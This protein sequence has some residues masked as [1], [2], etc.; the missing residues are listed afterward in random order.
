[1]FYVDTLGLPV[2][3][4]DTKEPVLLGSAMLA[5]CASRD[6]HDL[7]VRPILDESC[8]SKYPN[9]SMGASRE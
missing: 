4:P 6:I 7:E 8:R 5:A 2:I 9:T 1:M 3:I